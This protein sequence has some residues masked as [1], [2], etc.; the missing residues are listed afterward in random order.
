MHIASLCG[1]KTNPL[2]FPPLPAAIGDALSPTTASTTPSFALQVP[3]TQCP[4][5][6]KQKQRHEEDPREKRTIKEDTE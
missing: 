3:T 4:W 5:K 6:E 1:V 2:L